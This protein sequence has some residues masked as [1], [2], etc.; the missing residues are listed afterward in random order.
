MPDADSRTVVLENH[1]DK[2]E[3]TFVLRPFVY[4]DEED[5]I[6]CVQEEYGDTYYRREYYDKDLL[7]EEVK[8]GRLHLF[9]AYCG[10]DV[11]G[12]Q[13]MIFYTPEETRLEAASQ[14]FRKAYRGYGLAYELVKYTYEYAKK[15]APSCIYASTVVFHNLTQSMCEGAGMTPVAFNLGSHLT[16]RMKNSFD[17]G[18]SEKYAQAILI[19]PVAKKD[20]G[21]VYI[22]PSIADKAASLYG[23]LGVSYNI[24]SSAPADEQTVS[25]SVLTVSENQREQSISIKVKTI[26]SDLIEKVRDI[27]SSHSGKYWTIQLILPVSTGS[28]I[29]AYEKLAGEGFYFMGVRAACSDTEQIFMQYTKDVYF[30]FDE[31]VLTDRFRKLLKLL[32]RD[33]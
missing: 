12:I 14:I 4:G 7:L 2:T 1:K 31:F 16:S 6:K 5:V 19:L 22:H 8:T 30:N 3:K 9:M 20:L 32:G 33:K 15:L 21:D 18:S 27:M 17:L 29:N 26:G 11:C 28:A 25:G 13:S 24:I 10:Q 23:D